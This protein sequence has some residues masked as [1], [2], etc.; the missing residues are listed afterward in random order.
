LIGLR[1]C[2]RPESADGRPLLGAVPGFA[3]LF[4]AAG[5]GPW[6]ISTGPG[7]ARLVADLILGR[8]DSA[9][10]PG[11]VHPGR[12]GPVQRQESGLDR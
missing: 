5:N 9:G 7:S 4:V 3:G 2:A 1:H 12:F 8:I 11:A 10:L 6:G